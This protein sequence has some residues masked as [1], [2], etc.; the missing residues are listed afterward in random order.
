MVVISPVLFNIF[1]EQIM[2]DTI[3]K[4]KSTISVGGRKISNLRFTDDINLIENSN[5]E[6]Q[7]LTNRN[8]EDS[9]E[10]EIELSKEKS[11]TIVKMKTHISL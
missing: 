2:Q 4:Q 9:K 3:Q 11:K 10:Y 1:M 8:F 7:K 6:L 5:T